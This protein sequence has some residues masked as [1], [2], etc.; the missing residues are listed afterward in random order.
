MTYVLSAILA[1]FLLLPVQQGRAQP[2][3]RAE[4]SPVTHQR[5]PVTQAGAP[6]TTVFQVCARG[7]P[8]AH[9]LIPD[10]NAFSGRTEA[11]GDGEYGYEPASECPYW[12]V[13][14]LMNR[15]SNTW[16]NESGQLMRE[17]V[18]FSG[19]AFDLPSSPSRDGTRPVIEEDCRRLEIDVLVYRKDP[20][21]N[22]FRLVKHGSG[23][24]ASWNAQSKSCSLQGL[25]E[26]HSERAPDANM[27]KV[28]IAVRVKLR[29]SWQQAAAHA[30]IAPPN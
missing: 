9:Y 23:R 14:F 27:L 12:V 22:I 5:P 8:D 30:L 2:M 29:G 19:G 28:R 4:R 21:E 18:L 6:M 26:V 11:S 20:D 10:S 3:P 1:V 15:F 25:P 17:H 7:E 24:F 16:V 13:D